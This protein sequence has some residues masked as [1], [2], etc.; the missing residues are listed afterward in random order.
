M[1]NRCASSLPS[2]TARSV[3]LYSQTFRTTVK[4]L[5]EVIYIKGTAIRL[6][7]VRGFVR[8]LRPV[9]CTMLMLGNMD[10]S[11]ATELQLHRLLLAKQNYYLP[12]ERWAQVFIESGSECF[13]F[14]EFGIYSLIY[15]FCCRRILGVQIIIFKWTWKMLRETNIRI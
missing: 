6:S 9:L 10:Q 5:T 12:W 1:N 11:L 15:S 7:Y 13:G 2:N 3:F 8:S 4:Y 14:V